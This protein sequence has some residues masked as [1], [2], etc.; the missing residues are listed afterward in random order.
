MPDRAK[1]EFDGILRPGARRLRQT[2]TREQ[3]FE[4]VRSVTN[5]VRSTLGP[6]GKDKMIEQ[7]DGTVL[8]TND[9]ATI[10]N[11]IAVKNSVEALF[12]D[13]GAPSSNEPRDGTTMTIVLTGALLR[14][15][16]ALMEQGI[17][18]A[19]VVRG[20]DRAGVMAL[21]E[22]Q[23]ISIDGT[24]ECRTLHQ[25]AET[26]MTGKGLGIDQSALVDLVLSAVETVERDGMIDTD[27]IRIVTQPGRAIEESRMLEGAV[28]RE[29]PVREPMPANIKDAHVLLTSVP[30]QLSD[31]SL[32]TAM[33][34]QDTDSFTRFF[35]Q[36]DKQIR[37]IVEHVVD[38]GAN[39]VLC[40][41]SIADEAQSALSDHDVLGVRRFD[42]E[43]LSFAAAVLGGTVTSNI[44][45]TTTADLGIG[46]ITRDD[47][48][49]LFLIE[50]SGE[51]RV[52]IL[53]RAP[54]PEIG[55][56]LERHVET[57]LD[58]IASV[59]D[60]QL[61]AG[62]GAVEVELARRVRNRA[63]AV[64]SREQLAV[65][66][67]ANALETVPQTLAE[68]AGIDPIDAL[69]A[70]QSAHASGERWVGIGTDGATTEM[71]EQGVIEPTAIKRQA[72]NRAIETA[73]TLLRIDGILTVQE[74]SRLD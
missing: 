11:S 28:L 26:A 69:A 41:S 5:T 71:F 49:E 21:K 27:H 48:D 40:S 72:I 9:A 64:A 66:A 68:N 6:R 8:I 52:T 47:D 38:I 16:K 45:D 51:S 43:T 50:G 14:E 53:I 7:P 33:K 3:T 54:T 56:E 23:D 2:A 42:D 36:E 59:T 70:L 63:S 31:T 34:I 4:A 18:P 25:V 13:L 12:T 10:L 1:T 61:V 22:L 32:D 19:T 37:A 30:L 17:H 60:G 58:L 24:V 74:L 67:F 29:D 57:V 15:A 39:A 20:Y 55:E 44:M 62:G 35:Q 46:R 73:R 65:E